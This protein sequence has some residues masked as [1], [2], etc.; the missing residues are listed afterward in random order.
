MLNYFCCDFLGDWQEQRK[1]LEHGMATLATFAH[2]LKTRTS[3]CVL[4]RQPWI[5][6]GRSLRF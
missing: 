5:Q 2:F 1:L 4:L 3:L 6:K